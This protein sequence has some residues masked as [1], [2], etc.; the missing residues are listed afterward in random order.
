MSSLFLLLEFLVVSSVLLGCAR[1]GVTPVVVAV[2]AMQ[3][4]QATLGASIYW[5]FG[6]GLLLSPG[7]CIF[8]ASNIAALL[9]IY[10]SRGAAAARSVFYAIVGSNL[11]VV[12]LSALIFA[13]M[14]AVPPVNFLNL[15]AQV[16][17]H[18]LMSALTGT[19][20]L[21]LTQLVAL[22]L[23]TRV[24]S[25]W[26]SAPLP[27][28]MSLA[29]A[30]ALAFDTVGYLVPLFWSDPHLTNLLLSGVAS[31]ATA[32]VAFGVTWGL[33]GQ[34]RHGKRRAESLRH[35]FKVLMWTD[36][37]ESFR[38]ET[39]ALY[40]Q[41]PPDSAGSEA[42]LADDRTWSEHRFHT[43]LSQLPFGVCVVAEGK[44]RLANTNFVAQTNEA[45]LDAVRG[46][47]IDRYVD[48]RDIHKLVER[49]EIN[50]DDG[51]S[52]AAEHQLHRA[53]GTTLAVESVLM[54]IDFEDRP[55]KLLMVRD[56]TEKKQLLDQVSH[57]DRL[58]AVGTMTATVAH[59]INNPLTFVL[60]NQSYV[61]EVLE[62]LQADASPPLAQSLQDIAE[63]V[64]DARAGA[65]RIRSV[66]NELRTFARTD[67][68]PTEAVDLAEVIDSS[69]SMAMAQIKQR[70]RLVRQV[71][72][73]PPVEASPQRLGQVV[74]N[75][76]VNAAQA[77]DEGATSENEVRVSASTDAER[78]VVRISDTGCGIAPEDRAHIMEPFYTTKP[79][80]QG[81][82]LGLATCKSI[83][84]S[85][86]GDLGFESAVG[87]G[88]TFWFSLPISTATASDADQPADPP[89][90]ATHPGARILFVDDEVVLGRA[91]ARVMADDRVTTCQAG[92]E[93]LSRL[94]GGADFDIIFCDLMMPNMTG[95]QLYERLLDT[96]PALAER[97]VFVTGSA[98]TDSA[99]A[100]LKNV[101][102]PCLDKPFDWDEVRALVE[103]YH[104]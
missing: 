33:W 54:E 21:T 5:H 95:M 16:F 81:T 102:R 38:S 2:A 97:V 14:R 62:R 52:N 74:L 55:A 6:H 17:D 39:A 61:L 86:G 60:S 23:F 101:D 10:A 70:A 34:R 69:V 80:D 25:S 9:Y 92:A 18:S 41:T 57:A 32:G 44:I 75:L 89:A 83:I 22:T 13:H 84:E 26:P 47:A 1:V 73:L 72:E 77:I 8:F 36:R 3:F 65:Q 49:A 50:H 28:A 30:T 71:G 100:F 15:P 31:K 51:S 93:A 96:R 66:V 94:E 98:Y 48:A 12:V 4:I 82:G 103:A 45:S 20:V 59:E 11:L 99:T 29:L 53:D 104:D 43:W 37:A 67:H 85:F 88:S 42:S 7:S 19:I 76:L 63:A 90:A 40:R 78:V 58:A 79:A 91:F 87:E 68:Q 64:A 46:K 56:I 27:V 24:R 35:L